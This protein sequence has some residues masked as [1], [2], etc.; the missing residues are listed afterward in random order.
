M[1]PKVDVFVTNGGYGSVS[2]AM[3]FGIPSSPP[4]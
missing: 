1:L 3:S 4:G 2:Q